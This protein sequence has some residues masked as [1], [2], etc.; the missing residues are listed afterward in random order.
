MGPRSGGN[1]S[2]EWRFQ[3]TTYPYPISITIA[4][5]NLTARLGQQLVLTSGRRSV[6]AGLA[7]LTR[8]PSEGGYLTGVLPS[9]LLTPSASASQLPHSPPSP[10]DR[11]PHDA[12]VASYLFQHCPVG[13]RRPQPRGAHPPRHRGH[14]CDS[15]TRR[16]PPGL[17][18]CGHP[19]R[20]RIATDPDRNG[21]AP[22]L[23]DGTKSTDST[24]QEGSHGLPHTDPI[25]VI[26]RPASPGASF[27]SRVPDASPHSR[28]R[29]P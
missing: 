26:T 21:P 5:R 12:V 20:C 29:S 2:V 14:R 15:N 17:R 10:S 13:R 11:P 9:S 22:P 28:G 3:P 27:G 8:L 23:T 24:A 4:S 18:G 7:W 1:R 25:V 6:T 19:R 16:L